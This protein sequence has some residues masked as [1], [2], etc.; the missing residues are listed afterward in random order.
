MECHGLVAGPGHQCEIASGL[1][2]IRRDCNVDEDVTYE[3]WN[4][5]EPERFMNDGDCL[6]PF[7][8]S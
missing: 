7:I 4:A 6:F 1:G 5:R 2:S 8:L 3:R